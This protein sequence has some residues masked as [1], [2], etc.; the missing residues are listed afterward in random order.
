MRRTLALRNGIIIALVA[1]AATVFASGLTD[2]LAT[3]G[4]EATRLAVLEHGVE[5]IAS[6]VALI[7]EHLLGE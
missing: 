2:H 3:H 1:V 5:A 7:K 6:D 4:I